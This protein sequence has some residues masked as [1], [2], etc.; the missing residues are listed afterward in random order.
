M[1]P[2]TVAV[3]YSKAQRRRRRVIVPDN[4][5][6]ELFPH[7]NILHKEE[8]VFLLNYADYKTLRRATQDIPH[9]EIDAR[10]NIHL[11]G[12][13]LSD[14]CA[15]VGPDSIVRAVVCADPTIDPAPEGC[16]LLLCSLECQTGW[17]YDGKGFAPS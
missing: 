9:P 10:L 4:H 1:K 12:P 15:I 16:Q 14:R 13:A 3:V 7:I 6:G 2:N 11:G 8:G 5:D 17:I